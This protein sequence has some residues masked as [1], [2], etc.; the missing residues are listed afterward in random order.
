M[1]L[2]KIPHEIDDHQVIFSGRLSKSPAQLLD[3]DR[4]G[5]GGP[6]KKHMA[7]A[8]DVYPFVEDVHGTDHLKGIVFVL[9]TGQCHSSFFPRIIS[10][11]CQRRD[12]MVT[13]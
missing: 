8:R 3:K 5:L 7:Q 10:C 1:R 9:K 6:Q 4:K 13:G 2:F 11:K 12:T